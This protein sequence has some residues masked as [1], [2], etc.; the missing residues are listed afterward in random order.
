MKPRIFIN[1][2]YM[3]IGGAERALL[4][5][6]NAIDTNIVD[7]DLFINQHTGEFMKLLPEKINLLPEIS[8][9]S[10]IEKPLVTTIKKG[11]ICIAF[12][13]LLAKFVHKIY[14]I[15]LRHYVAPPLFFRKKQRWSC[16]D[17]TENNS[18]ALDFLKQERTS[19]DA[20]IFNRVAKYTNPLLPSLKKYGEYDLAISFLTP[21]NIVK[22][23][24]VA[25]KKIAWIHTDY[26]TVSIDVKRELPIWESFNHIVSISPDVSKSFSKVFPILINKIIE[27]ENILSPTF[28]KQQS[29]LFSPKEYKTDCLNILSIGR[30]CYAKNF[31]SIPFI[32]KIL[33]DRGLK[34]KWYIIG[35]GD[36]SEIIENICESQT[37]DN[38]II[39]GKK[40][41]PY[42]YIANCDIYVQPSRYEGKSITVRE[43]QILGKL[44]IITNYPTA[45]SQVNNGKDGVICAMDNES[46]VN[47]IYTLANDNS[48]QQNIKEFLSSHDF[49]NEKEIEK[50]YQLINV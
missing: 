17:T 32:A 13:R 6:L 11:H 3:E 30:F 9:Y 38:V 48:M 25:K 15:P 44:V 28:I 12:A 18:L 4:G 8:A 45:N 20:S 35:F 10:V 16:G 40:E 42:P 46:I 27:I 23:K 14:S 24:V 31:E 29:T 43:A 34:F 50:I 49:G 36:S 47:A 33:K 22:D 1:M 5:L 37:E 41:N 7:V 21:H 2:H 26:A 19:E 39:L